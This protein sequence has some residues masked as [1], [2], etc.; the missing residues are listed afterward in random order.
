MEENGRKYH[1]R[2]AYD[3][4]REEKT[5]KQ[6]EERVERVKEKERV[7]AGFPRRRECPCACRRYQRISQASRRSIRDSQKGFSKRELGQWALRLRRRCANYGGFGGREGGI[8]RVIMGS[9]VSGRGR[10]NCGWD[11]VHGFRKG[12]GESG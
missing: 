7:R 12:Q 11:V 10:V 2:E 1:Q 5:E 9:R 6:N 8:S 3:K 4:K